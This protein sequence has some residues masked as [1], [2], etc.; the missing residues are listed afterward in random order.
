MSRELDVWLYGIRAATVR[1]SE[2]GVDVE[3]SKD[4]L[5]RWGRGSRVVSHLL[6]LGTDEGSQ[7]A[8]VRVWLDGLLP[9]G[10]ARGAMAEEH[11]I[12]PLDT[13]GM[14]AV[15]GK[16]T[17]GALVFVDPGAPDPATTGRLEP[18]GSAQIAAMLEKAERHGVRDGRPDSLT[19]LAG[20]EPKVALARTADGWARV[21]D[22]AASTHILKL[23]RPEG[24][25]THDL[26]DTESAAS[27]LAHRVGLT[28]VDSWIESFD[29]MRAIVVSRYDRDVRADD[30]VRRIHQE[31]LAQAL[32]LN[33][34][35]DTRK[36]QRGK[37]MPSYRHASQVL[38]AAGR[39]AD[40]LLRLMTF[41]V[42]VGNTDAHAKNHAFI[43]RADGVR[44]DLAPAY[45]VSMHEHTTASSHQ[46]AMDIDGSDRIAAVTAGELVTE[47]AGWGLREQ[48]ARRI[49][50]ETLEQTSAAL[51]A[52]SRE[53][54]PGVSVEAWA[55]VARRTGLL[56]DEAST[57]ARPLS[58]KAPSAGPSTRHSQPRA[59]DGRFGSGDPGAPAAND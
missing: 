1:P 33:T 23:S 48:R 15:Y 40:A 5:E 24:S 47:A 21:R 52:I 29:G 34:S 17:A 56:L 44:V 41:T 31:D 19:S 37:P 13:L 25:R 43:R 36:F 49:V 27:D 4:A 51:G 58:T 30:D 20:M 45:D 42:V 2:R 7:P 6:P 16:D 38:I 22:G 59:I 14:L 55:Q 53:D 8:R 50:L 10:R 18:V 57:Y 11:R 26:I 28:T 9:E 3:W 46:L 35:D 32:G 39:P 54:H 12:D